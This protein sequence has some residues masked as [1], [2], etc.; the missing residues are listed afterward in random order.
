[1]LLGLAAALLAVGKAEPQQVVRIAPRGEP[2]AETRLLM[3]GINMPNF[4]GLE[5]LLQKKSLDTDAWTFARGQA[6]LIAESG[7]LLLLRPPRGQGREAWFDAA[8]DLRLTATRVARAT[9]GRDLNATKTAFAAV[10]ASCNRC[11]ETFRVKVRLQQ[12]AGEDS[13][14]PVP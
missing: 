14:P 2:V 3:Q 7:N 12:P 8:T 4:H 9:A 6:L 5:T 1:L 13:R 11:H 10:A